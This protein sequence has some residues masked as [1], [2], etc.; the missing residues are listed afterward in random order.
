MKV[1]LS[2]HKRTDNVFE[3]SKPLVFLLDE[4]KVLKDETEGK[5]RKKK[6]TK[7][8][9]TINSSFMLGMS[10]DGLIRRSC[11]EISDTYIGNVKRIFKYIYRYNICEA[12]FKVVC[13]FMHAYL[14]E[15][16][17]YLRLSTSRTMVLS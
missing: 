5:G 8:V 12:H 13:K 7:P 11:L 4:P 3:Q 16:D 2:H 9:P 15:S 1:E 6:P 10:L 14:P 17:C